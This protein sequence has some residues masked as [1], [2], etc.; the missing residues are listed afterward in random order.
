MSL[1]IYKAGRDCLR[2]AEFP[3]I[4]TCSRLQR[5]PCRPLVNRAVEDYPQAYG[6]LK[7]R[8]RL[9]LLVREPCRRG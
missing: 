7:R 8:Q 2:I 6:A 3:L 4:A 1:R 9:K 5:P